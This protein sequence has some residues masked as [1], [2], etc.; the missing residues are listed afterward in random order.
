[1]SAAPVELALPLAGRVLV[2][3]S[4]ADRVPSHGA[5]LFG[6]TYAIDLV[7]VDEHGRSAPR[8]VRS[9]LAAEPPAGFV[10]F[11]RPVL[12]PAP[13]VVVATHDGE[14]DGPARRAPLV[15]AAYALT[16]LQRV[17]AGLAAITGNH[18][19]IEID[20]GAGFL[21]IVHLRAGSVSAAP[22]DRVEVGDPIGECGSSGNSTEPH[23]HMHVADT[24]DP[25]SARGVP[26][27]F[28]RFLDVANGV[29]LTAG[30]PRN[31][32]IVEPV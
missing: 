32:S 14:P 7:P 26:I 6:Q 2:Q 5:D 17:R 25:S 1:M 11:G 29:V 18:V 12:A 13:G 24:A 28:D 10:G 22:G 16:Q 9:W 19:V 31:G 20:G 3:N 30:L 15:V 23:V 21:W 27:A 4:P 8:G